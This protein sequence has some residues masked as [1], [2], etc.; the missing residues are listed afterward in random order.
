MPTHV[1][2]PRVRRSDRVCRPTQFHHEGYWPAAMQHEVSASKPTS[3]PNTEPDRNRDS[4]FLK[5]VATTTTVRP[6]T[7]G[8]D[9]TTGRCLCAGVDVSILGDRTWTTKDTPGGTDTYSYK[10]TICGTIPRPQL[11]SGCQPYA[12][13]PTFVKYSSNSPQ[14]CIQIGQN[15][16][17]AVLLPSGPPLGYTTSHV[18]VC[19]CYSTGGE[20]QCKGWV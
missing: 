3:K 17:H 5:K 9:A 14:N 20:P 6:W 10:F 7:C 16:P 4:V 12:D 8:R 19:S 18:C 11:P 15:R 13:H 1:E 2:V